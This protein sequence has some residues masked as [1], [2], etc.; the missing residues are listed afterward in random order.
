MMRILRLHLAG[1][2]LLAGAAAQSAPVITN[3]T[4]APRLTIQSDLGD[5]NQIQYATNLAQSNWVTLTSLVVTQSPYWFADLTAPSAPARFYRVISSAT[6]GVPAGMALIPAGSYV[7]GDTLDNETDAIPTHSVYVSAFYMDVNL[8][9]YSL[10]VQ[11]YQWATNSGYSF[12]TNSGYSGYGKAASHPVELVSWFDAVKWCNARSEMQG[13]TPCYY[14]NA[15]LTAVYRTGA[16][17][18]SNSMVNWSANGYRLP[19]EAEWE[20][21]ARGGA[22]GQRF[23]WADT[24][25]I[26]ESRANF[27]A[28]P[29]DFAYDTDSTNQYN[30]AF[31][32]GV[33]PYTSPVGYFTANGYGLY[34]MAGNVFQWCW[35]WY[36]STWYSNA[37]ATLTDTTGPSSSD[38]SGDRVLRGGDWYDD[39]RFVRSAYRAYNVPS[40]AYL[41][42]GF[43]CLRGP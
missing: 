34:D 32:D 41:N 7:M 14:T 18:L 38:S 10:W 11:V 6:N 12:A 26:N 17:T 3:I 40:A 9:S 2:T 28:D 24:D 33:Y 31:N 36:S 8:V 15:A 29:E 30:L 43:R 4:L 21:A 13:L 5:T 23:P 16:L 39:A 35:D 20:K 27:Q 1:L 19:T 25:T 37:G 22:S 42:I